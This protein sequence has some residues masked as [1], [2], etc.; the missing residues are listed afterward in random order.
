M[1]PSTTGTVAP[2]RQDV[3]ALASVVARLRRVL[4][5]SVRSDYAWERLPMAQVEILQRLSEE[6][7]LRISDL[8]ARHRLA[9]N[10]VSNLIQ[11]M[12][13]AGLVERRP[14]R[15][16]RRAVEVT[17]TPAGRQ[18]LAAWLEAN[19]RRLAHAMDRLSDRDQR[20]IA[21]AVP[22]LSRLVE[23]LEQDDR[24]RTGGRS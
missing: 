16:D 18:E 1:S 12:V 15:A 17:L 11:Q 5:A 9:I 14:D 7:G 13:V 10:T 20:A 6:P 3:G 21:A 24:A 19:N 2:S 22:S 8:A 23:Q 4:R